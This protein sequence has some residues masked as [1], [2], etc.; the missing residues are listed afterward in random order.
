M[1]LEATTTADAALARTWAALTDVEAWPRWTASV[2][3]IE[4]LDDGPLRVG[5]RAKIKQPRMPVLVWEVGELREQEEFTWTAA[6]PGVRMTG[7]HVLAANPDGTTRITLEIEQRGPLAGLI[8][9]L[10]NGRTRRY[11]QMEAAGLKAASET[12]T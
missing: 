11:L 3:S 6:S 8:G 12:D 4:L 10:T 1:A 9:A 2:T 5:S 7:R